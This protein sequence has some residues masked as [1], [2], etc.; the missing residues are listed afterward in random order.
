MSLRA[1]SMLT[2]PSA[3]RSSGHEMTK[4]T[5]FCLRLS[6][7]ALRCR[8]LKHHPTTP[9]AMMENT[10][11]TTPMAMA[12]FLFRPPCRDDSDAGSLLVYCR[13]FSQN[14]LSRVLYVTKAE[15]RRLTYIAGR[16]S[17]RLHRLMDYKEWRPCHN[18]LTV[19]SV[20]PR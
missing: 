12:S 4:S 7:L 1:L 11:T 13:S 8:F 18:G 16:R 3:S 19:R 10:P 17:R 14:T 2:T 9:R 6:S 5:L 20:Y 15:K